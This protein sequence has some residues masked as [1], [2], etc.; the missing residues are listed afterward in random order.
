MIVAS[1]MFYPIQTEEEGMC[2]DLVP[3]PGIDMKT[4]RVRVVVEDG[5]YS[6]GCNGF[7]MCGLICPHIIR[8]MV[9]LNVQQVPE[10]YMLW[11]WSCAATTPAP[12]PGTSSIRFGIPPTNTLKYNALCRKMNDLASDACFAYN[13]YEVVSNMVE[14][15]TKVVPTMRRARYDVQQEG[16]ENVAPTNEAEDLGT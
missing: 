2:F 15:A 14:Q 9:L 3:N 1:T 7:E 8:V 4:Y 11:R 16:V 10:R 6:C 13:T 5:L 12:Q